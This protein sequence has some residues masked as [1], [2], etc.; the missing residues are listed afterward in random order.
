MQSKFILP[1]V[2]SLRPAT[3]VAVLEDANKRIIVRFV[4]YIIIMASSSIQIGKRSAR[5]TVHYT[6]LS[7][8]AGK[9]NFRILW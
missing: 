8:L 6:L 9:E 3:E 4:I 2:C 1:G 7:S 5:A